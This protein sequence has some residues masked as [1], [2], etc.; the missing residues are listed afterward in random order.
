M[1]GDVIGKPGRVGVERLLPGL[2]DERGIDFVTA[3]GENVAGGM[4]LTA[5]TAEALFAAG[6]DVITSGNHIW[7]KREIYPD[8]DRERA[9]PAPA[10]LRHARRPGPRLGHLPRRATAREIAVLNLQGR[11]YM[12]PIENPFTD[13]DRLLDEGADALPPV[14]LVDFHCE[15]T[16]EKNAFGLHLDGRVSAV[17]RHAHARR[18][19]PTSGSCRGE[20]PTRRD[21]GMTGPAL[22]R[23]RLRPGDGPAALHQRPADAVRGRRRA[24]WSSTRCQ[25]DV[26]PATGRALHDRARPAARRGL[27]R[28]ARA[29]RHDGRSPPARQPRRPA[30]HTARSDGVLEPAELA[31]QATRRWASRL[32]RRS[33]TTTRLAGYRELSRG[34]GRR[35]LPRGPGA[36]PG[37]RDQRASP[38]TFAGPA[39]G[40]A[41]RPGHRRGPGRRDAFEARTRRAAAVPAGA[42]LRRASWSACASIGLPVDAQLPRSVDRSSDDVA[43]PPARSPARWSPPGTRRASTTRSGGSSATARP[44]Y[45]PRSGLDPRGGDPTRSARPAGSPS[46]AH[47]RR[48]PR[49]ARGDRAAGDWGLGGLETHHRSLRRGHAWPPMRRVAARPRARSR[50]AAPTSTATRGRTPRRRR[51]AV[52]PDDLVAE[53]RPRWHR[54]PRTGAWPRRGP[55]GP[56]LE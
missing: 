52:V 20:R 31:G 1:I 34:R 3:N 30:R 9:D 44:G 53:L 15:I 55:A 33:P 25:I 28:A 26:D 6:V 36:G 13:A 4:G 32:A 7:D 39:G 19:R 40:G 29:T 23:D 35:A 46:L 48:G 41:P 14:R 37:G 38:A 18:R 8:L 50:P 42:A 54:T 45:V 5:S 11:T 10:Q 2:R 17:V 12:Q 56:P 51:P 27:T 43:R 21:L 22:Q 47:F 16:S 49:P 24:R